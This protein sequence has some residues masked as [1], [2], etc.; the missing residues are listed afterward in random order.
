MLP[1]ELAT[2]EQKK[3]LKVL[4]RNIRRNNRYIL[5]TIYINVIPKISIE[6]IS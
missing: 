3:N 5:I 1:E 6:Q 2:K 4:G